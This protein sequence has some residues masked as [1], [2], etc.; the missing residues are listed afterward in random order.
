MTNR[1]TSIAMHP[2]LQSL[3]CR[4]CGQQLPA[5]AHFCTECGTSLQPTSVESLA[6]LEARFAPGSKIF[7]TVGALSLIV[8]PAVMVSPWYVPGEHP[9]FGLLL[10]LACLVGGLAL[11]LG[12]RLREAERAERGATR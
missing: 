10:T 5:R 6:K 1:S 11:P 12:L 2:A 7:T 9:E 3:T 4:R 8:W